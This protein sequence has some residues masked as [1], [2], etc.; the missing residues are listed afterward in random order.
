MDY[1]TG[2]HADASRFRLGTLNGLGITALQASMRFYK[3]IG[4]DWCESNLLRITKYLREKM[5]GMGFKL[6]GTDDELYSSGISTFVHPRSAELF[7]KLNEHRIFT[8]LRNRMLRF[9]PG[10]Y[11]SL[12]DINKVLVV[13]SMALDE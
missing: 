13:I 7:E 10:Y 9:S 2:L 5:A 11:S 1:K 8:A 6:Y 12:D 3:N 4:P